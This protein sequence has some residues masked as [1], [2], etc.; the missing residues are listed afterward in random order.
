MSEEYGIEAISPD[1][2]FIS[3]KAVTEGDALQAVDD[4]LRDLDATDDVDK[5]DQA[6]DTLL[7]LQ[8]ISGKALASLLYGKKAWWKRTK[9]DDKRQCTFE[10][11]EQSRHGLKGTTID[12]YIVVWDKMQSFP[13]QF[14]ERPI[15]ELIPVAKAVEQ[16]YEISKN[17]WKAL[18]KA[19]SL[20][21]IGEILRTKVKGKTA[22]RSSR[23]LKMERDGTINVWVG[24]EPKFV[25]YV[26]VKSEDEDVKKAVARI[27]GGAG[28]IKR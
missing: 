16:G 3:G 6:E 17:D 19:T 11:Y 7:G 1:T 28:V 13:A 10:D 2:V 15:R 8:R 5:I 14:Q 21:E 12:R 24:S 25:G 27:L 22:R 9:Q 20:A 4:A 23:Q 26:D 18:V